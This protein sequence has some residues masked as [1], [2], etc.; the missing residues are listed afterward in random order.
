MRVYLTSGDYAFYDATDASNPRIV[1]DGQSF[2]L[3]DPCSLYVVDEY[4][5]DR[6]GES[7]RYAIEFDDDAHPYHDTDKPYGHRETTT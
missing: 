6:A 7:L 3:V 1:W 5:T 2:S 4:T